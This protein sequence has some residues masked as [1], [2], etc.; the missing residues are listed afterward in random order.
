MSTAETLCGSVRGRIEDGIH[1]FRGIPFAEPPVGELRLRAPQP[2]QPWPGLLDVLEFGPIAQQVT[3]GVQ[4]D[5]W[6]LS[7]L[8]SED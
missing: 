6:G 1:V 4:V 8:P 3:G 5:Y 7:G 2:K